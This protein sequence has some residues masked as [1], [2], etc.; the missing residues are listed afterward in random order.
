MLVV[1]TEGGYIVHDLHTHTQSSTCP[2]AHGD[3]AWAASAGF[4]H[5]IILLVLK[6][7]AEAYP[8]RP[9]PCW[10]LLLEQRDNFGSKGLKFD[11]RT[12]FHSHSHTAAHGHP[13]VRQGSEPV[14]L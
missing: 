11:S 4:D 7:K 5:D 6:P 10:L 1:P 13:A 9:D 12:A 3:N 2:W 14:Q 8:N